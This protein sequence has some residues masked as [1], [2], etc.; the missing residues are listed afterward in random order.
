MPHIICVVRHARAH[1]EDRGILTDLELTPDGKRQAAMVTETIRKRFGT[2]DVR[3]ES[4]NAKRSRD[5]AR[6]VAAGLNV[7]RVSGV[8]Y[9]DGSVAPF[10]FFIRSL[11]QQFFR[12]NG[13]I[14]LVTHHAFMNAVVIQA[15]EYFGFHFLGP[16][17]NEYLYGSMV[18]LDVDE[19]TVE[20]LLNDPCEF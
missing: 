1:I 17:A 2:N 7:D 18:V 16:R 12:W 15:T 10:H 6:I 8:E 4:S 13:I 3:I 9:M 11:I 20:I 5:T 14:I 19:R